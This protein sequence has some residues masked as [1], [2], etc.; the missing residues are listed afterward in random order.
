VLIRLQRIAIARAMSGANGSHWVAIAAS[1]WL[2]RKANQVRKPQSE[3]V[4]RAVLEPGQTLLVDHTLLDRR[5]KPA[6]IRRRR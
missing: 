3:V 2:L 6:K 5:G 1:V 4:Y